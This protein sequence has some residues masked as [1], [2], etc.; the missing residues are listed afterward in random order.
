MVAVGVYELLLLLRLRLLLDTVQLYLQRHVRA[1]LTDA[2]VG[3]RRFE[4]MLPTQT[5]A[6]GLNYRPGGRGSICTHAHTPNHTF[7]CP[8]FYMRAGVRAYG[9]LVQK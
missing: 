4:Q 8:P 9:C 7:I 1:A 5:R 6:P 2:Q 3:L